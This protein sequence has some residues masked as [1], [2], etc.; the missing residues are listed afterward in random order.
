M[1]ESFLPDPTLDLFS[2]RQGLKG[3]SR[4]EKEA[5]LGALQA[6]GRWLTSAMLTRKRELAVNESVQ[7]VVILK[8]DGRTR[9][10]FSIFVQGL[11]DPVAI[12]PLQWSDLPFVAFSLRTRISFIRNGGAWH[13][14]RRDAV[15]DSPDARVDRADLQ[16]LVE[17]LRDENPVVRRAALDLL[18]R[19]S[20]PLSPFRPARNPNQPSGEDPW[21]RARR[22]FRNWIAGRPEIVRLQASAPAERKALAE[23][24]LRRSPGTMKEV[25]AA[26]TRQN[27]FAAFDLAESLADACWGRV[28]GAQWDAARFVRLLIVEGSFGFDAAKEDQG[29]PDIRESVRVWQEW[30][31]RFSRESVWDKNERAW[32]A[33]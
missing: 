26:L 14:R 9:D 18:C 2:I 10:E 6:K 16:V 31:N 24:L 12:N 11:E 3:A 33:K 19:Y 23:D 4:A 28:P 17:W 29:D 30:V 15:V 20:N 22:E 7:V 5:A 1:R 8:E 21:T 27:D 13:P 32:V 25:A